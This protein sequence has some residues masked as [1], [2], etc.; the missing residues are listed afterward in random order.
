MGETLGIAS[1]PP[2]EDGNVV[3][4]GGQELTQLRQTRS[5]VCVFS[6]RIWN[7]S[8]IHRDAYFQSLGFLSE[9]ER[10]CIPKSP[11]CT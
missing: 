3:G 7:C 1:C 5:L 8:E 9:S 6:C 11:S 2:G 10:V 4:G